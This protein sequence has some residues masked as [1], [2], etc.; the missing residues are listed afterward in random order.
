MVVPAEMR[1][2]APALESGLDRAEV[3]RNDFPFTI[4]RPETEAD[5]AALYLVW[6]FGLAL[7]VAQTIAALTNIIGRVFA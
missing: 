3:N 6:R 1:S 5:L 7:P 4:A 2:P